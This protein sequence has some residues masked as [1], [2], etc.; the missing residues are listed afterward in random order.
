MIP[1]GVDP[2]H[3]TSAGMETSRLY[4]RAL[5]YECV[6]KYSCVLFEEFACNVR[7][8]TLQEV[9]RYQ[10]DL[11]FT[12]GFNGWITRLTTR[13]MFM[14]EHPDFIWVVPSAVSPFCRLYCFDFYI[15]IVGR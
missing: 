11:G 1:S 13:V 2:L 6:T 5:Y 3:G 9:R 4:S 15:A 14:K 8:K 12:N 7:I 10:R